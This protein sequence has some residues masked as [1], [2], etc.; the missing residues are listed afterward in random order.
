MK[1]KNHSNISLIHLYIY[2]W[3]REYFNVG[4]VISYK[5][6]IWRFNKILWRIPRKHYDIIIKELIDYDLIEK[7]SGGRSPKYGIDEKD[8][9]KLTADLNILEKST[10]RFKIL[11]NKYEKTLKAV[12]KLERFEQKYNLLKCDYEKFLR[13]LELKKLEE[14]HYW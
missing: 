5:D 3:L 14:S 13:K 9:I 1:D 2:Q 11:K 10:Q 12:E 8:Y 4:E 7:I 6:I